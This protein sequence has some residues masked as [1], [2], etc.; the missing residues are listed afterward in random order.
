M[1]SMSLSDLQIRT[2]SGFTNF[3][4]AYSPTILPTKISNNYEIIISAKRL[5]KNNIDVQ[6]GNIEREIQRMVCLYTSNQIL[7]IDEMKYIGHERI[8]GV[9]DNYVKSNWATR[10]VISVTYKP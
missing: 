6:L 3:F 8:Y 4:Q 2:E 10:I 7:G 1:Q 5:A 9:S